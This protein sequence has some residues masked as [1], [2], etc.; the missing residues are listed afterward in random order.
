MRPSLHQFR[1]YGPTNG[2]VLDEDHQTLIKL[3]GKRLKSYAERFIPP[4]ELA[5]QEMSNLA[6]NVRKFLANDFHM[7]A[8]MKNLIESFYDSIT[9]GTALPIAYR[10]IV[11]VSR[12]MDRIFEQVGPKNEKGAAVTS[13]S[14]GRGEF[15]LNRA[16]N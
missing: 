12:I 3:K 2:L 1:L 10:E 14:G 11:L 9:R 6:G 13:L 16:G 8:G 15:V 7:K 5:K 4:A